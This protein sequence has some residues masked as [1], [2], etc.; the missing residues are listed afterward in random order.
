[1]P[2]YIVER[3]FPAGLQIPAGEEGAQACLTVVNRNAVDSV[4]WVHSYVAAD[5]KKTFCVYDAPT[6]EAIRRTANDNGLPVDSITEV[7]AL[8]PYFYF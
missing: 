4:T 1:M 5:K 7:R 8:D 3:T 6:P 2:R